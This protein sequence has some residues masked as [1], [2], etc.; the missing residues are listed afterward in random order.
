MHYVIR[1]IMLGKMKMN[2]SLM[3]Y[4][5]NFQ[6]DIWVPIVCWYVKAGNKNLLIDTG[7]PIDMMKRYWYDDYEENMPFEEG[8]KEIANVS[9]EDIDLVI[10]THLHFD[11]CGNTPKCRNAE[12][13]VQTEELEFA[14]QPHPLFKGSYL[15]WSPF[16]DGTHFKQVN[17][18]VE[19]LP[20]IRVIKVPGH[21]PGT[22][23]VSIQT[24]KGLMV[25][26]GFCAVENNFSPP[27]KLRK[28]WPILV[29]GVHTNSLQAFDSAVRLK[30]F[31]GTF[32]PIHDMESALK[33]Q[34]P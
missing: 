11:H 31:G 19:I 5:M 7:A 24:E 12:V 32:I 23:A 29:T 1:P 20:D 16:F 13:I 14:R 4:M 10:Q 2:L 9:P 33:K 28:I 34:I 17:G 27:E 25:L 18:D 3:T 6:K 15:R 22:Q 21:S 26:S 30:E 8:L